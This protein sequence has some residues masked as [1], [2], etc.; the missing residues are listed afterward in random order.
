MKT[1]I[2]LLLLRLANHQVSFL[3]L[4]VLNAFILS[5]VERDFALHGDL[6]AALTGTVAVSLLLN[7]I[8]TGWCLLVD[9]REKHT[10]L[11]T[12]LPVKKL[13]VRLSFWCFIFVQLGVTT[14]VW[15]WFFMQM[16]EP[17]LNVLGLYILLFY[18]HAGILAAMTV[19]IVRHLLSFSHSN[20]LRWIAFTSG[21]LL[22]LVFAGAAYVAV[23][24]SSNPHW[25]LILV[26]LVLVLPVLVIIDVYLYLRSKNF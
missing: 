1:V 25:G 23:M 11:Y 8:V 15:S 22:L 19:P 26:L 2:K 10:R 12:E 6:H 7:L 13:Q 24:E 20:V 3:I 9:E 4:A 16:A 14:A 21:M 17:P 5:L 18:F